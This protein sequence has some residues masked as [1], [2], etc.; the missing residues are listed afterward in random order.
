MAQF[1][2]AF[3]SA[4]SART[5]RLFSIGFPVVPCS[6]RRCCNQLAPR[7]DRLSRCLQILRYA[8]LPR[9][10][11]LRYPYRGR[12]R[13]LVKDR[14]T[15]QLLSPHWGLSQGSSAHKTDAL[16]L[17]YRGFAAE[18]IRVPFVYFPVKDRY[19]RSWQGLLSSVGRACAS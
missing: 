13:V 3:F 18:R 15:I 1:S 17:S 7:G 16:P 2:K 11:S 5:F 10:A 14:K 12:P 19:Q 6:T 8:A 4:R 9:T